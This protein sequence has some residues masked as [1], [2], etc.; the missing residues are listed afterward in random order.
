MG[1][2]LDVGRLGADQALLLLLDLEVRQELPVHH[3]EQPELSL[4]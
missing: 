1:C 4:H 2:Y 3:L